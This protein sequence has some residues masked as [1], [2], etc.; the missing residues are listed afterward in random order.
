MRKS[1]KSKRDEEEF[2]EAQKELQELIECQQAG[3]LD[4]YYFDEAGFSLD[5]TVPYAWRPL[6]ETIDVPSQKSKRINTLGFLRY[7]SRLISYTVEGNVDSETVIACFNDFCKSR[8]RPAVVVID[9]ASV[10]TSA[11]VDSHIRMAL[12]VAG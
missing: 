5:P 3:E 8:R 7:D 12:P 10:H 4:L 11:A 6:G 2:R 1:L 9:N